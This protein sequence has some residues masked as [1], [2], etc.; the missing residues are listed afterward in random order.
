[1][2]KFFFSKISNAHVVIANECL[3][4]Y[5]SMEKVYAYYNLVFVFI[6]CFSGEKNTQAHKGI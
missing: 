6:I 3:D 5:L 2:T 4:E 1:M